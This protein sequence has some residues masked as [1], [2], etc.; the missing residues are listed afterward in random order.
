MLNIKNK[1]IL[2]LLLTIILVATMPQIFAQENNTQGEMN[3]S[4]V[5]T[6]D[7]KAISLDESNLKGANY[8]FNSSSEVDGNGSQG[9][10]YNSMNASRLK[11]S[12][13]IYL[14]NGE[15]NLSNSKIVDGVNL[16]GEN[17]EKTIFRYS[18]VE[19]TGVLYV[20]PGKTFTVENVTLIGFNIDVEGGTFY[21]KNTI[22]KDASAIPTYSNATDLVNSASNS[23]GGAIKAYKSESNSPTVYLESCTLINNTGEYGGAIHSTGGRI[24]LKKSSF[25]DNYAYNYGGAIAALSSCLIEISDC[26]FKND[27]SINDAGGAIYLLNSELK[28]SNLNISNASATFG[29]AITSLNSKISLTHFLGENN[30]AKYEGGAVYAL[31]NSISF[32]E[33]TFINNHA[34]NGGAIF[35]DDLKFFELENNNFISNIASDYGGA[36]HSMLNSIDKVFYNIF[37]DNHAKIENDFFETNVTMVTINEGNYTLYYK[38]YIDYGFVPTSYDLR[39]LNMVTPVKDQQSGGNCWAFSSIAALESAILKAS[40]ESLDLSEE[41]MKNI[42]QKYS[43]YGWSTIETN[44]GGYDEMAIGYLVNWIG[45]VYENIEKYDDYSMLSPLLNP[46][47]HI[48]NIVYLKR[49][50]Y[51]DN[52]EIKEAIMK[53][54]AVAT[55]ICF[56]AYSFNEYTNAYYYSMPGY[57]NHGVAIVGWDDSYSRDN[58]LVTPDGDGAWI[59]K[60]SWDSTWGDNGYFYVSYYDKV[61]AEVGIPDASYAFVFNDSTRY[62]KNYQYDLIG[63]TDYFVSGRNTIWVENIF[64]ATDYDMLAG[65][66]TYFRKTTDFVLF[67][68]V[69]NELKLTKK[70][71]CNPGYTTINLGDYI[72]LQPNDTF[73]VRFKLDCKKGAEFAISEYSFASKKVNTTG[74]SFFSKDGIEWIDLYNYS[75]TTYLN[76]GHQYISQVAAIK[77]FTFAYELQHYISL[78]VENEFNKANITAF[79]YDQFNNV[80]KS[81]NLTLNIGGEDYFANIENGTAYFRHVFDNSGEFDINASYKNAFSNYNINITIIDADINVNIL[82][83]KNNVTINFESPYGI[84]STL[85][86]TINGESQLVQLIDGK[87]SLKLDDLIYGNYSLDC[88]LIDNYY[89]SLINSGFDIIINKTKMIAEDLIVYYDKNTDYS[90][91]LRDVNGRP[92]VNC[93]VYF[94]IN[95]NQYIGI[96]NWDGKATIATKLPGI[97]AYDIKISFYGNDNYFDIYDKHT[98]EIKSSILGS[99]MLSSDNFEAVLLNKLGAPLINTNVNVTVDGVVYS[100]MTNDYGKVS[101]KLNDAKPGK[102]YILSIFNPITG[103]TLQNTVQIGQV[104]TENKDISM[105]YNDGSAFS[106]RISNGAGEIVKFSAGGNVYYAETDQM[107]YAS[108]KIGL[109]PGNYVI[110]T[111]YKGVKVSNNLVVKKVAS[112]TTTA[113]KKAKITLSAKNI[114]KKKAKK[115]I[116]SVKVKQGTKALSK[117]KVTFKIKGNTYKIKTN[118]KGIAKLTLKNLKVGKYTIYSSYS[119]VKI[120]NTIKIKK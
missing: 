103:E 18:G 97:G 105:Y 32:I 100:V 118:K 104:I 44:N 12:S 61:F 78:S 9:N 35:A 52:R 68:Y 7:L 107:G 63:K 3:A 83:D 93:Q 62:E 31:Y 67:I 96:T 6:N 46:I 89:G 88:Q 108:I 75:F 90:I 15:Y 116:F 21:A 40:G 1:F 92:I 87:A 2:L 70:G 11:Q 99:N 84:N 79:I 24:V 41:N 60:N 95:G 74:V 42:M 4:I 16:I 53:Y 72:P 102:T 20:N 36:V 55:G 26:N 109:Q 34:R 111:S 64:N 81:G 57:A 5:Q 17:P 54:G 28:A 94:I 39:E 91:F 65:V 43:D 49:D 114:S 73:K 101:L 69:N 25:Y 59:V 117:I 106:V 98:I 76:E 110:T 56:S 30:T 38:D 48:Q 50:S 14:A 29:A 115:I 58:F 37:E 8:Y 82:K 19:N 23:F 71:T 27:F 51:T 112:T 80:V 45:P 47:T 22:I 77:A 85:N 113:K 33:S 119:G 66:S 10:P 13:T 86:V 120:K